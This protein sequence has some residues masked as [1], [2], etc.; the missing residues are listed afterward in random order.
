VHQGESMVLYTDG[1]IDAHGSHGRFGQ[2]LQAAVLALSVQ[3]PPSQVVQRI[4]RTVSAYR[5]GEPADDSS[6]LVL[7]FR[8]GPRDL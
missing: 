2:E 5:V 3:L 8:L 4:D 1:V 6:I 7:V